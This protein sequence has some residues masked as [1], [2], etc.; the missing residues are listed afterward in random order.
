MNWP[1]WSLRRTSEKNNPTSEKSCESIE[2]LLPL[3]ADGMASPREMRQVESHLPDCES[4]RETLFWMQATHRALAARPVALPPADLHSRIAQ[5]IAASSA[6]PISLTPG[7]LRPTRSFTL[8][9]AYAA[10]A[11]LTVLGLFVSLSYPLWHSTNDSVKPAPQ[12]PHIASIQPI[13]KPHSSALPHSTSVHASR[14]QIASVTPE[15]QTPA[16]RP[17]VTPRKPVPMTA[18]APNA[19]VADT[20][21]VS[22]PH[23][24]PAHAQAVI[25]SSLVLHDKIASSK[26]APIEKRQ[27][28]VSLKSLTP[29]AIEA[30]LIARNEKEPLPNVPVTIKPSTVTPEAPLVQTASAP[31]RPKSDNPLGKLAEFTRALSSAPYAPSRFT[32]RQASSGIANAAMQSLDSEPVAYYGAIHSDTA[33]K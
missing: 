28:P 33:T 10:A 23:P 27:P 29:K 6:A 31:S 11:S 12:P 5:A 18:I 32:T 22:A 24:A 20:V 2:P 4:C 1:F 21:P 16:T 8:R 19:R 26:A 7:L 13:L 17:L 15:R 3:Y 30:P 9:P 14:P 25:H